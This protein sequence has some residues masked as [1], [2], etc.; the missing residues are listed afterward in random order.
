MEMQWGQCALTGMSARLWVGGGGHGGSADP[1]S[2]KGSDGTRGR[3][4]SLQDYS[5]TAG[6]QSGLA[7]QGTNFSTRD[8][9][10]DNCLCKCAQMLSGGEQRG[11]GRGPRPV[12]AP[13]PP[14][15]SL[16]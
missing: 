8:A 2:G 5:G 1:L 10:N 16:P 4:L 3:R 14:S 15:C 6:Q 9:D 7:M 12:P 11:L 13:V